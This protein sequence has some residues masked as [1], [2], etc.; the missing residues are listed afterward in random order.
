[1]IVATEDGRIVGHALAAHGTDAAGARAAE[2][3]VVVTSTRQRRGIGSAL[4]TMLAAHAAARGATTVQ[5]ALPLIAATLD[6]GWVSVQPGRVVFELTPGRAPL[7][8]HR[9]H[10]R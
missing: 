10:A 9:L 8:S 6:F 2:I 7:R 1:M 4:T 5:I 3:G